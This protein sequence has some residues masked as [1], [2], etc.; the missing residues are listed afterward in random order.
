MIS[1]R[2]E[3]EFMSVVLSS[4]LSLIATGNGETSLIRH[5]FNL[6]ILFLLVSIDTTSSSN[7]IHLEALEPSAPA[8]DVS[9]TT[10]QMLPSLE[11]RISHRTV[12]Q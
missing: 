10:P 12:A 3:V 9:G 5:N 4:R 8:L 11:S 1:Y 6:Y 2:I 7:S